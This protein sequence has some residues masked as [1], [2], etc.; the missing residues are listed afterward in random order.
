M[1]LTWLSTIMFKTRSFE[2]ISVAA[3]LGN[4]GGPTA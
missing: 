4:D 3:G 2:R 1:A